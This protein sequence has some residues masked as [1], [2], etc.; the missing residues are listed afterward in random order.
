MYPSWLPFHRIYLRDNTDQQQD[1]TRQAERQA[2]KDKDVARL[3]P[4]LQAHINLLR[5]YSFSMP[6]V[7]PRESLWPLRNPAESDP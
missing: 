5:W 4:L 6:E 2:V 7:G 3:S 1:L